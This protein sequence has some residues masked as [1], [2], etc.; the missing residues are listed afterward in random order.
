MIVLRFVSRLLSAVLLGLV[1]LYRYLLSPLLHALFP[2][3][4]CR[5][6]P[7]C[8]AYAAEAIRTH[9]PWRGTILAAGRLSRCHPWGGCGYDPVPPAR[10]VARA[11][12]RADASLSPRLHG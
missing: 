8:S 10:P 2:G 12:R 11:P 7:T 1:A 6:Q 3:T 9:G 4:G 5:Y